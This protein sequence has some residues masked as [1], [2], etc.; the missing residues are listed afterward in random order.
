[1]NTTSTMAT[2]S[3]RFIIDFINK[4]IIGTKASF[5]KASKGSG[6]IYE[7]LATKV[8]KH[9]AFELVIKEQKKRINKP[10]KVYDGL[11]F[12]FM[13]QY[14]AIHDGAES[15]MREFKAVKNTYKGLKMSVY[16][17]TKKWFLD[18]YKGFDMATARAEIVEARMKKETECVLSAEQENKVVPMPEK[19]RA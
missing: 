4:Q 13:E 9:P 2:I 19:N 3:E 10:K 14:I 18:K 15:V 11:T 5:D 8:A 1:M 6:A 7:E 16:P 17:F 12:E